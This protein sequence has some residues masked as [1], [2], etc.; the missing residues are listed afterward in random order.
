MFLFSAD[1][2][3]H[4]NDRRRYYLYLINPTSELAAALERF[5]L[6]PPQDR[7]IRYQTAMCSP[8][9]LDEIRTAELILAAHLFYGTY[10]KHMDSEIFTIIH[11]RQSR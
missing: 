5:L 9:T 1:D 10:L 7:G 2:V 11:Y 4:R 3:R 8:K 6:T